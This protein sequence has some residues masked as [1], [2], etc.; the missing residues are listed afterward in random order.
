M[1]VLSESLRQHRKLTETELTSTLLIGDYLDRTGGRAFMR[2]LRNAISERSVLIVQS[3]LPALDEMIQD[4]E[5]HEPGE[6]YSF[7][8]G[9][10]AGAQSFCR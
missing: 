2:V 4:A 6:V 1:Y 3:R 10:R 7:L 9:I 5:D 8:L